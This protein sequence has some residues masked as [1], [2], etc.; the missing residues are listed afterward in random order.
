LLIMVY[1]SNVKRKELNKFSQI[2]YTLKVFV[3][4]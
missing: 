1:N 2:L 3:K 4:L